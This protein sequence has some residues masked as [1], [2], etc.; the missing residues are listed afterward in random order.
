MYIKNRFGNSLKTYYDLSFSRIEDVEILNST[1][2]LV[3]GTREKIQYKIDSVGEIDSEPEFEVTDSTIGHIDDDLYFVGDNIGKTTL[4]IS[5]DGISDEID[6]YVTDMI[7]KMPPEF[8][9]SKE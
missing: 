7:V 2:Y 5:I 6:V 8:D 4:K 1:I 9:P 3:P